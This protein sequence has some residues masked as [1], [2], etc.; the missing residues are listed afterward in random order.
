M[1]IVIS[2][3]KTGKSFQKE[4]DKSVEQSFYS[5]KIGETFNGELID[6]Q[7]YSFKIT[8]GSDKAGFPMRADLR[9]EK[10]KK[11]LLTKSIGLRSTEKGYRKK[12][13]VRGNTV[14]EDTAQ[15][16]TVIVKSGSAKLEEV[17]KKEEKEE[18][19]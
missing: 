8:G 16:N 14:G 11:I 7:G 5:K 15:I 6:L 4:L 2:D 12:K 13:S 3:P 10:R 18:K 9:G 1:K 19:K 17:F